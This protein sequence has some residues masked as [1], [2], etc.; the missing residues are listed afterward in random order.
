MLDSSS[1]CSARVLHFSAF[2]F[3]AMLICHQKV[4][5]TSKIWLKN[6]WSPSDR[7]LAEKYSD[8]QIV[9]ELGKELVA[10]R[11]KYNTIFEKVNKK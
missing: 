7:I 2:I 5:Y 3:Y 4:E 9:E 11:G 1:I 10:C 8:E 6:L